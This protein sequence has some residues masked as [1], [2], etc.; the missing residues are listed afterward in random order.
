MVNMPD[1]YTRE[2]ERDR[3]FDFKLAY[4]GLKRD[5]DEIKSQLDEI[6][7]YIEL[8]ADSHVFSVPFELKK[9]IK[10][11]LDEN[12]NL[13][14]EN[15]K[16]TIKIQKLNDK[17]NQLTNIVSELEA[18][19]N[20]KNKKII[21]FE[22]HNALMSEL[23]DER[24]S[25][26]I[27]R[28]DLAIRTNRMLDE[29]NEFGFPLNFNEENVHNLHSNEENSKLCHF[30]YYYDGNFPD[31]KYKEYDIPWSLYEFL[32]RKFQVD[33]GMKKKTKQIHKKSK[34][35]EIKS[36]DEMKEHIES[37]GEY[38]YRYSYFEKIGGFLL[39]HKSKRFCTR[40]VRQ[41][42]KGISP[43]TLSKHLK[44]FGKCNLIYKIKR[45]LY[46]VNIK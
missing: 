39:Q 15:R 2:Q 29:Q 21:T 8:N 36:I 33:T 10:N 41:E 14:V 19:I 44:L 42:C 28:R 24:K 30:K 43:A 11:I 46:L 23:L 26:W 45:G 20:R 38:Y 35:P 3:H 5:Y 7:E 31:G 12:K 9:T 18:T 40:D 13:R 34:A 6:K 22:K 16:L 25:G 27:I 4:R 17:T 37:F 1:F 32:R